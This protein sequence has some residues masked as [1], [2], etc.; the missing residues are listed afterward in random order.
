M[1][2]VAVAWATTARRAR[3]RGGI[4]P[5]AVTLSLYSWKL[6]RFSYYRTE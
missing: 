6:E 1:T 4:G 5:W 2:D 3:F